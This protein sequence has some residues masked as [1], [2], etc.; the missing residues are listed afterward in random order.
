M[1]GITSLKE[2]NEKLENPICDCGN[3]G[4]ICFDPYV[5]EIAGQLDFVCYCEECYIQSCLDI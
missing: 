2:L 1:E 5:E 3:I 4:E